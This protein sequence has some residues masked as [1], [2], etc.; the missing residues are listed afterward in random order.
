M[1]YVPRRNFFLPT[2]LPNLTFWLDGNDPNANGATPINNSIQQIWKDK[3]RNGYNFV[4]NSNAQKPTNIN[5][6]QHG[7]NALGFDIAATQYMDSP[8][9]DMGS[10]FS[11][12]L[13]IN[14]TS[15]ANAWIFDTVGAPNFPEIV[16]N[17]HANFAVYDGANHGQVTSIQGAGTTYLFSYVYNQSSTGELF[18]NGTSV[19]SSSAT[20]TSAA[21]SFIRRVGGSNSLGAFAN[22]T[23]LEMFSCS[24]ALD[25]GLRRQAEIYIGRKWNQSV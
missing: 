22:A 3:S 17:T 18:L 7:L 2:D 24:M 11:I 9:F 21:G 25:V 4:Q 23:Y 16:I 20:G 12:F 13:L 10:S 6:F 1:L 5:N 19:G 14:F 15:T 8:S